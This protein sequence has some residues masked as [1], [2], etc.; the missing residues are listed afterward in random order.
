MSVTENNRAQLFLDIIRAEKKLKGIPWYYFK[1]RR[2][3]KKE[4][5]TMKSVLTI[6]EGE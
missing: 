1:A 6:L 3:W 2:D 4:I 5:K